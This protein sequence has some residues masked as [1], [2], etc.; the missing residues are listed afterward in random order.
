MTKIDLLN[1]KVRYLMC[2]QTL[3]IFMACVLERSG[4]I[5]ELY[6]LV[7]QWMGFL[8]GGVASATVLACTMLAAMVGVIGATS[9]SLTVV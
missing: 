9:R 8:K 5:E 6:E 2:I 4:I 3:F 7:Y 1:R